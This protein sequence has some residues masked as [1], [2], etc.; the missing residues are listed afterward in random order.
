MNFKKIRGSL[1]AIS[2]AAIFAVAPATTSRAENYGG[3][4]DTIVYTNSFKNRNTY[5]DPLNDEEQAIYDKE[6]L[7]R[8]TLPTAVA[9]TPKK[10][11][12]VLSSFSPSSYSYALHKVDT[13]TRGI[14]YIGITDIKSSSSKLKLSVYGQK[15]TSS[16]LS[17]YQNVSINAYAKKAGTYTVSFNFVY[18]DKDLNLINVP[19]TIKVIAKEYKPFK[20]ITF[21]GKSLWYE[22]S[23]ASKY[24]YS[25]NNFTTKKSGKLIVKPAKG[26]KINKIE[27]G[28]YEELVLSAEDYLKRTGSYYE[29]TSSTTYTYS[30]TV[31]SYKKYS[32]YYVN[33]NTQYDV[34]G[35]RISNKWVTVKSGAKVK[36]SQVLDRSINYSDYTVN[37]TTY[38]NN[39][40]T[41]K[42]TTHYTANNRKGNLAPTFIRVT[43]TDTRTG[44]VHQWS[45]TIYK[46]LTK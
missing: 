36:L 22:K 35:N 23:K 42:R 20:K 2:L 14:T 4:T 13:S 6:A 33:G 5:T 34:Y 31:R 24:I 29:N 7:I 1:L 40:V 27:V 28:T 8:Y 9:V 46:L 38:S 18:L 43:Y 39:V 21:G 10:K 32:D 25:K 41:N 37:K 16:T 26:F 3:G 17:Y 44:Q 11:A 12:T 30:G 19:K 45:T 15:Y